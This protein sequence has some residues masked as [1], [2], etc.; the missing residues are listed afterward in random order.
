MEKGSEAFSNLAGLYSYHQRQNQTHSEAHDLPIVNLTSPSTGL[1][2]RTCL[3]ST[4]PLK[5]LRTQEAEYGPKR[6]A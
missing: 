6:K 5:S 3:P 4:L 2:P 1:I